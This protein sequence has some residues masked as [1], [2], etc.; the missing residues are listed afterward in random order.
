MVI[1]DQN[2][3]LPNNLVWAITECEMGNIWVGCYGGGLVYYDGSTFVDCSKD[4]PS[5]SIRTLYYERF[6]S[7]RTDRHF[8]IL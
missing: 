8:M 6:S 3:G 4:I 1:F 2:D 5:K 7:Y